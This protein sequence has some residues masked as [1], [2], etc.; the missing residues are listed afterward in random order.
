MY[1][2]ERALPGLSVFPNPVAEVLNITYS[3]FN[4]KSTLRVVDISGRVL[5]EK[6]L[7]ANSTQINIPVTA[8]GKGFNFFIKKFL[9]LT[10]AVKGLYH[11][12]CGA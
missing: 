11:V 3:S 4:N 1:F 7:P 10:L 5:L 9:P 2:K 8:L 6:I 12:F